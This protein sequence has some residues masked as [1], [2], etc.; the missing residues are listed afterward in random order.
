M[1]RASVQW[2]YIIHFVVLELVFNDFTSYLC[3]VFVVDNVKQLLDA[4]CRS[5]SVDIL[6]SESTV[7][8][9]KRR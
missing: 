9:G 5:V 6:H 8:H 3:I 4:E 2:I 7:S 1:M